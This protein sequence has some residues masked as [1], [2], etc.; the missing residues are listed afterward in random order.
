MKILTR[1]F[2]FAAAVLYL[3]SISSAQCVNPPSESLN[4]VWP[5]YAFVRKPRII[6]DGVGFGRM[7]GTIRL[8]AQQRFGIQ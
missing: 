7:E 4:R 1:L 2:I 6:M 8:I 3:A 5:A